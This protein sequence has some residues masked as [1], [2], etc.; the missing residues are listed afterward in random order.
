MASWNINPLWPQSLRHQGHTP[1]S[2]SP[3]SSR[4]L[5]PYRPPKSI[6]MTLKAI[7]LPILALSDNMALS[8]CSKAKRTRIP[9][10]TRIPA[11]WHF[12][13]ADLAYDQTLATGPMCRLFPYSPVSH[14]DPHQPPRQQRTA[15]SFS[16]VS[17][18]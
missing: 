10:G 16:M 9:K 7:S 5:S 17:P 15:L 4:H 8:S 3:P 1:R 2:A 12:P 11:S 13:H 18:E 6:L 14:M